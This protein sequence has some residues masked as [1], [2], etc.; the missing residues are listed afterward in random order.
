MK[1]LA[2]EHATETAKLVGDC[3]TATVALEREAE[4]ERNVVAARR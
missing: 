4:R 3:N 1:S 2:V